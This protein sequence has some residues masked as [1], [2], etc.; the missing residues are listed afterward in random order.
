MGIRASA[1]AFCA[2]VLVN[3]SAR[4]DCD[5]LRGIMGS[6]TMPSNATRRIVKF[7]ID[8]VTAPQCKEK[9]DDEKGKATYCR[10]LKRTS[11]EQVGLANDSLM[12]AGGIA[13]PFADFTFDFY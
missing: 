1:R 8:W 5:R 10:P 6:I 12:M 11:S 7:E 13:P 2:I 9:G 4:V 3:F